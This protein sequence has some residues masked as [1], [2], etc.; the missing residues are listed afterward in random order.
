M[1]NRGLVELNDI[2][3][4]LNLKNEKVIIRTH[5]IKKTIY[6]ILKKNNNVIIDLTCP[7]VSKIHK[8]VS[9]HSSKGYTIVV[10]GDKNHPEVQGI[11]S[12]AK[13]VN[14]ILSEE[15]INELSIDRNEPILVVFQTT[16]NATNAQ[17]LVDILKNIYYNIKVVN[18][19]CNTTIDRQEEIV[20]IAK[21]SNIML[22]VGSKKSSNTLKL[23]DISL[24]FCKNTYIVSN[25]NE[26]KNITINNDAKVGIGAGASTPQHLIEEILADVRSKF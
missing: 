24:K 6:D 25:K 16:T 14:V 10:I 2:S 19:I 4:I 22:I 23:Y 5:G 15:D 17:N 13:K 11:V 21:N 9:E 1:K 3:D 12:Y 18:T 26:L 8:I 7:F 20:H